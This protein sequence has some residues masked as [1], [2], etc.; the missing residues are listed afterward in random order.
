MRLVRRFKIGLCI[1][2]LT[3]F[4]IIAPT[5]L[6]RVVLASPET[7]SEVTTFTGTSIAASERTT[8]NFT[9]NHVEWRIRWEIVPNPS[10]TIGAIFEVVTIPY[11][12]IDYIHSYGGDPLSGTVYVHNKTGEFY[13][14]MYLCDLESYTIIVEQDVDSVPEFT[15]FATTLVLMLATFLAVM[16]YKRGRSKFL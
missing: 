12:G 1:I 6:A 10:H 9:C 11:Y 14:H 2:S 4:S 8:D 13:M 5:M 15:P 16:V 7:W 3:A